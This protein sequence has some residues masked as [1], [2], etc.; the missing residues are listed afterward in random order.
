[1][2]YSQRQVQVLLILLGILGSVVRFAHPEC[3][4]DDV[5]K[6]ALQTMSGSSAFDP[7]SALVEMDPVSESLARG[8]LA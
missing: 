7:L 5:V 2:L 4:A 6:Y 8:A 3:E 1:M